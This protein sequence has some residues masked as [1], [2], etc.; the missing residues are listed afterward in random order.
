M[1]RMSTLKDGVQLNCTIVSDTHIDIKHPIPALPKFFVKRALTNAKKSK[2]TVD[3]FIVIGDTTSRSSKINWDMAKETFSKVKAP[4]KNILIAIG[5]HDTWCDEDDDTA[6]KRYLS[7]TAEITGEKH[8]KTYFSKVINGY[9][10]IFLGGESDCGCGAFIS[11]E[12]VEWFKNEMKSA[13]ESGKP[14][15]VFCHQSLNGKHGLP[16]T[17]DKDEDPNASPM[18]GGIGEK[19]DEI[20]EILEQYKNVFYFSG[21]S[22]MG[23]SGEDTYKKEGYSSFEKY[24]SLHLINLPSLSC[25]NHHGINNKLG[26]GFQLE[27]YND[28]VVIRPRETKLHRWVKNVVIKDGKPY[29]EDILE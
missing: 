2:N 11:D 6:F 1:S 18:E 13:S 24:G 20:K 12:Q 26:V 22:H 7:Y 17:F 10:L 4:A 27:V 9:H 15:F 3:A 25:G 21:H 5:N 28:S 8:E 16:R 29:Y 23:V 14:V 19:S